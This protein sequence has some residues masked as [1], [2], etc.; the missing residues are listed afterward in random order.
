MTLQLGRQQAEIF[1]SNNVA[2]C[3]ILVTCSCPRT[4]LLYAY[5]HLVYLQKITPIEELLLDDKQFA[6]ETAKDIAKGRLSR[7]SLIELVQALVA[8]NYFLNPQKN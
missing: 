5:N 7:K 1:V 3:E 6:W 2:Y 8:L 4:I